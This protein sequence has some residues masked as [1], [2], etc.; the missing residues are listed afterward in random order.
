VV[1]DVMGEQEKAAFDA[2]T[3][4][5]CQARIAETNAHSELQFAFER[6]SNSIAKDRRLNAEEA[7][8]SAVQ[9]VK[10]CIDY[11]MNLWTGGH[12]IG[13]DI[14][15][16]DIKAYCLKRGVELLDERSI[17]YLEAPTE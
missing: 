8:K 10:G 17:L 11:R 16:H 3:L 7:Y 4:R 15:E 9:Y 13:I 2:D 1:T 12:N 6:W 5:V 14:G